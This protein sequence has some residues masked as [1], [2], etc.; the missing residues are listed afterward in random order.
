MLLTVLAVY[1]LFLTA[2]YVVIRDILPQLAHY[3]PTT[4]CITYLIYPIPDTR[5]P[6]PDTR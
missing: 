4:L 2:F 3:D 6:I 1:L 5:Y